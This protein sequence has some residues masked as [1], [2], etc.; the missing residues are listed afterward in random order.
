M[1][2][3]L[4]IKGFTNF[5]ND[6]VEEGIKEKAAEE[7]AEE[8]LDE[9]EEQ[10]KVLEALMEA[11]M[12]ISYV[13][14]A[15]RNDGVSNEQILNWQAEGNSRSSDIKKRDIRQNETDGERMGAIFLENV[16]KQLARVGEKTESGKEVSREDAA[17]AAGAGG[18]RAAAKYYQGVLSER[19]EAQVDNAGT[20]LKQVG[21]EYA[22]RRAIK[23]GVNN[24][25]VLFKTGQLA[26]ALA[27]GKYKLFFDTS[28]VEEML[29]ILDK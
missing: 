10:M 6:K 5:V 29:K 19:L 16:D 24:D 23:H 28:K 12:G 25:V 11:G 18:L 17:R 1:V 9:A 13:F 21:G 7:A 14:P 3:N 2:A 26:N 22:K 4:I 8:G 27:S 20:A 15:G